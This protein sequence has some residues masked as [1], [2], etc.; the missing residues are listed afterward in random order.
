LGQGIYLTDR[1]DVANAISLHRSQGKHP[2]VFTVQVNVE[3]LV[4]LGTT[5]DHAAAWARSGSSCATGMHPAWLGQ[6]AFREYVI[7]DPNRCK[8]VAVKL[9]GGTIGA[10]DNP[11]L[12]VSIKGNAVITGSIRCD[13]LTIG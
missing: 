5:N 7:R 10:I 4:D 11:A 6:P 12:H 8:L 9:A 1:E 2:V 13:T 3:S